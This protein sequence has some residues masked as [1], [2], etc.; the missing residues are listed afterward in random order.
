MRTMVVRST[1]AYQMLRIIS[2]TFLQVV[3]SDPTL[4][5]R[6]CSPTYVLLYNILSSDITELAF[7]ALM[8]CT[9]AMAFG[10]PQQIEYDTNIHSQIT[11]TPSHQWAHSTPIYFQ[12]L[13]AD[14]NACRDKSPA[15]R[16]WK[17]IEQQLLRWQSRSGE[18]TFTESWMMVAWYAVQESWRLALLT[19]LYMASRLM[20][21]LLL[22]TDYVLGRLRHFFGRPANTIKH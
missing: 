14:I 6:T 21:Y 3:Y 7:F 1:N 10:I 18:Y 11:H 13:L 9:C 5:P 17:D 20:S 22:L 8:D 19:Y 4:W 12:L 2:P 15:A 16:D